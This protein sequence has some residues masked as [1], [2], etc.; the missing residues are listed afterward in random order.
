M[1]S[2]WCGR[3]LKRFWRTYTKNFR[4]L[5]ILLRTEIRSMLKD[6]TIKLEVNMLRNKY[7]RD[8]LEQ[9]TRRDSIRIFGV[10]EDL[11]ENL[12]DKAMKIAADIDVNIW[13]S[14]VSTIHRIGKFNP[15]NAQNKPRPITCRF[16]MTTWWRTERNWKTYLSIKTR[17]LSTKI[18][19]PQVKTAQLHQIYPRSNQSEFK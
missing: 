3:T 11:V 14:D 9:Y 12:V 5:L 1:K 16:V 18:Y 10:A 6:I 13:Q 2:G 4:Q 7:E 8:E 19:P 15:A 17:S